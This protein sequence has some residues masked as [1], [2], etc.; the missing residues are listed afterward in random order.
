MTRPFDIRLPLE[1]AYQREAMLA[2]E[3]LDPVTLERVAHG[4]TVTAVGLP[5]LPIVNGSGLFVWLRQSMADFRKLVVD[6]GTRPFAPLEIAAADV[7]TPLHT[8]L[9]APLA[10][11]PFT[12]GLTVIRATLVERRVPLG[13]RPEPVAGAAIRLEWLHEDGIAW[14]DA[15]A[16]V[17]TGAAGE[18]TV[19]L[20]L[21]AG[22]VPTLDAQ[23]RMTIRLFARRAAG[24]EQHQEFQLPLGRVAD[25]IHAW[26]EL[27]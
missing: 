1:R 16:R 10:S 9:L 27:V 14:V 19:V 7:R 13:Q 22:Q 15:P 26:D 2:V 11:Y 23:G 24:G 6:P 25:A 20:R 5:G 8:A 12:A 17:R 3:L 18:F 4:V 21:G